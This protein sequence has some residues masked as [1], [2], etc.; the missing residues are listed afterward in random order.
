MFRRSFRLVT[1]LANKKQDEP[2]A[3]TREEEMVLFRLV[4][5]D[6]VFSLSSNQVRGRVQPPRRAGLQRLHHARELARGGVFDGRRL[7]VYKQENARG[8]GMTLS[9]KHG[10]Q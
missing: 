4:A 5:L 9:D 7:K 6:G 1:G 8:N 3:W 10:S 2:F